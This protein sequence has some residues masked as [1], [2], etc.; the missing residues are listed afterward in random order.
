M[1]ENINNDLYWIMERGWD[2]RIKSRRNKT[3]TWEVE[4]IKLTE[5]GLTADYICRDAFAIG[6]AAAFIRR[7][8]EARPCTA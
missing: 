4:A 7:E 3:P 2:I 6:D 8:I 5:N 1:N